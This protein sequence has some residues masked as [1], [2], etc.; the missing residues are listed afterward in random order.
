MYP[1]K[2]PKGMPRDYELWWRALTEPSLATIYWLVDKSRWIVYRISGSFPTYTS[3]ENDQWTHNGI[4][5][6]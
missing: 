4:V 2:W 6:T 3:T 5:W 1:K